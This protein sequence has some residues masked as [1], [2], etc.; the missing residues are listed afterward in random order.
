MMRLP[1]FFH[2]NRFMARLIDLISKSP[3]YSGALVISSGAIVAQL[4]SIM[5]LLFITRIYSPAEM[6]VLAVYSSILS[7]AAITATFRYEFAYTVTKNEKTAANLFAL[8]IIILFTTSV[9]FSIIVIFMGNALVNLLGLDS[10]GQ[11]F[12]LLIPGFIGAGLYSVLNYWA[13]RQRDY[14]RITYTK[15]NQSASGATSKIIL[16]LLSFGSVGLIFGHM[17]SQMA[18]IRSLGMSMWK[19]EKKNLENISFS[20]IKSVAKEHWTF[21]AF[22]LPASFVNTLSFQLPALFLVAFYDSHTVGLYSLAHSLLVLPISII[23][24]SIGQA[25]LGEVSKMVREESSGLRQ[26]YLKT[27]KH[28]SIVAIPSIGILAFSAP[29]LITWVFGG[30]WADAGLLCIPLSLMV[31]PQFVVSPTTCLTIYGYNHWTL[32]WDITRVSG[33]IFSFYISHYLGFPV[34]IT[35]AFYAMIMLIMY[36]TNVILNLKAISILASRNKQQGPT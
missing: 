25:F 28:L 24:S 3:L 9:A 2:N 26:L 15:I 30:E 22:N 6:G 13:I 14:R 20:E 8:C 36:I 12:W 31:I 32:I 18:G 4:I 10:L 17:I 33:V 11:Y 7:I 5:S 1:R 34:L 35:I 23:S 27:I 21:P 16:G 19:A 29:F